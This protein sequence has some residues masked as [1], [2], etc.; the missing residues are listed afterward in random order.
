MSIFDITN[1]FCE[2]QAVT[3]DAASTNTIDLGAT[4]KPYGD[5]RSLVRDIGK[6][7]RVPLSIN[8]TETFNN[9]TSVEV[10][11]QTDD[12]SGFSS[13]KVVARATYLLAELTA[14]KQLTFPD[15]IPEG[16]N[17]QFM[18]L[19]FDITGTAPSTGKFTAGIVAAR[20]SNFVGGQ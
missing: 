14:G 1:L 3:A 15:D 17:E 2:D 10:Q 11:L 9:L 4:G 19:Y 12:N 7:D 6:G 20:H 13:A 5:S 16:T 8:V 18:R